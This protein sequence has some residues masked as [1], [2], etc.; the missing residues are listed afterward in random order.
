MLQPLV[1]GLV[2]HCTALGA[3]RTK[4]A[5]RG[6][7][8][9]GRRL[10][11]WRAA[12]PLHRRAPRAPSDAR[13]TRPPDGACWRSLAETFRIR[14]TALQTPLHYP[15]CNYALPSCIIEMRFMIDRYYLQS[16]AL[17]NML[18]NITSFQ[19]FH[20]V[21]QWQNQAMVCNIISSCKRFGCGGS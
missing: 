7:R 1:S 8:S 18:N 5:T 19:Q 13:A 15:F 10:G 2:T 12:V 4:V 3:G 11:D 20:F 14:S 21:I 9:R 16:D 6:G 17:K